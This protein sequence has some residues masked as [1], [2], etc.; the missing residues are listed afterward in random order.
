MNGIRRSASTPC[1]GA[2]ITSSS[3]LRT[4]SRQCDVT[5]EKS[6]DAFSHSIGTW[7]FEEV[8]YT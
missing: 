1:T 2:H 8:E 6:K 7:T 5:Y 4:R 3:Y